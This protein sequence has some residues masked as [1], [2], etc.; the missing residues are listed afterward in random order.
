[1][2]HPLLPLLAVLAAGAIYC[3]TLFFPSSDD[4]AQH[5]ELSQRSSLSELLAKSPIQYTAGQKRWDV[6]KEVWIAEGNQQRLLLLSAPYS[7][8][9]LAKH[10]QHELIETLTDARCLYQESL[11]YSS[12]R[13]MQK[14]CVFESA[15][16]VLSLQDQ[17][18]S[19]Q[20]ANLSRY[21]LKGHHLPLTL[22]NSLPTMQGH[23][24]SVQLNFN[25][26]EI[27][28]QGFKASYQQEL[29]PL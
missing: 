14:I 17:Q 5:R 18:L 6:K 21:F 26:Q 11:L 8:I 4:R 20:H 22:E 1:M 24:Q 29:A 2:R 12:R 23:A 19:S 3:S 7:E 15:Q 16:A 25:T 27:R 13:P 10:R 9:S 28:T